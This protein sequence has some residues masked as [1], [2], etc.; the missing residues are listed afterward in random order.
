MFIEAK[1]VRAK[2]LIGIKN[3]FS[4][5]AVET[6]S[7]VGTKIYIAAADFY[8][9]T[10][11]GKFASFGPA[12][13]AK[14]YARVDVIDLTP[15]SEK[16]INKIEISV[17]GYYCRSLSTVM[18]PSFLCAEVVKNGEVI[19]ATGVP[20]K[21][22]TCYVSDIKE[23]KTRRFSFQRHFVEQWD[24]NR[25]LTERA[26]DVEVYSAA[27]EFIDRVAPYPYYED[28][29]LDKTVATG[30]FEENDGDKKAN[31]S[32]APSDRW[33]K[34]DDVAVKSKEWI[35]NLKQTKTAPV[36]NLPVSAKGGEYVLFD[37]NRIEAGFIKLSGKAKAG[38]QIVVAFSEYSSAEK[39]EFTNINCDNVIDVTLNED[40]DFLSFEPYTVKIAAVFVKNGEVMLESFGVKTFEANVTGITVPQEI[41]DPVLRK[42]YEGAIRTYAHNAVDIYTDCPSRER[43]GW[44]CDSY[45]TGKVE[46]CL[47]NKTPVEDAFLENYRIFKNEN[48]YPEGVLPM[49]F[50]S[51]MQDDEQFIP[52][53]TMWYVLEVAD[54]VINRGHAGE[55][56][57]FRDSVYG[58][59][60]FYKKYENEDG[61]LEDLPK[62]NFVEWS[63]ANGWTKNV[64]YPTN[65]LYSE[66]LRATYKIFGDKDALEKAE[67]VAAV[68]IKQSFDGKLFRDH[69]V[70]V[71]GKLEV[72]ADCSEICQY[73]AILFGG[74]DF[75]SEK[76]KEFR[77]FV[78]EVFVEDRKEL[79]EEIE[80]VNA[81]IGAYLRIEALLKINEKGKAL[82]SVKGF[83]GNMA[84]DTGTLWENRHVT[85]S[86]DHGFAS[87]ALVAIRKA[88]N[89]DD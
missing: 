33:G 12:R 41:K 42:V 64:N 39:F 77:R 32:V 16:K 53:W 81:F 26:V 78:L 11:N 59:L 20:N 36:Q 51:D 34:Y 14:G 71:D 86:L 50:P 76:Y 82:Q 2:E 46:Y 68:T 21:D 83:F 48:E 31:Y 17:A 7:L 1:S 75:N 8:R 19:V 72:S 79:I 45:F 88:L 6:A 3:S 13:T 60:N 84:N 85:G 44:I 66:T 4:T 89:I 40:F 10:V 5:F 47:F 54:Y 62:W 57:K 37:F 73:Y 61:L 67:R 35:L 18:Q 23:F 30:K 27:P 9:L 55:A 43:A 70:R 28:V 63:R 24:L 58:L 22:F 87:Y 52:Q 25:L 80:P 15:Y 38:T 69:A 29:T 49:C 74:F 56:E 65:F